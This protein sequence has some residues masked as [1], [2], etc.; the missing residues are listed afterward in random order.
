MVILKKIKAAT[1]LETLV[2]SAIIVIIFLIASISINNVFNSTVKTND[3]ELNNR[4]HE[5]TYLAK[6]QKVD[7]PFIEETHKWEIVLES[8]GNYLSLQIKN[9]MNGS[10]KVVPIYYGN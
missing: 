3:F 1:L 2:A 4:L 10:E 5:I 6:H 9:K 8:S 7:L